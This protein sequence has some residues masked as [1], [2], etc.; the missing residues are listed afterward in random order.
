MAPAAPFPS[1]EPG[2]GLLLTGGVGFFVVAGTGGFGLSDT[3]GFEEAGG[4]GFFEEGTAGLG[5]TGLKAEEEEEEEEEVGS[6]PL[7]FSPSPSFSSPL[8]DPPDTT[9]LEAAS[10]CASSA[11]NCPRRPEGFLL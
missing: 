10:L 7:S 5:L 4:V 9:G 3:T 1:P 2:F 8:L 11:W 6:E